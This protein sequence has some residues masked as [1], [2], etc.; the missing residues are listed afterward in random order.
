MI[1]KIFLLWDNHTTGFFRVLFALALLTPF[2][3]SWTNLY[4]S[5]LLLVWL[6]LAIGY[7]KQWDVKND[8]LGGENDA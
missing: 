2:S 3:E 7:E 6:I 5:L 1:K 8:E 4:C